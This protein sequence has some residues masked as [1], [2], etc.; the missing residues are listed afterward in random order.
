MHLK[1]AH[2]FSKMVWQRPAS[3]SYPKV[4]HTFEK[5]INGKVQ[6]FWVQDVPENY[7]AKAV[8]I[9]CCDMVKDEPMCRSLKIFYNKEALEEIRALWTELFQRKLSVICLTK[10]ENGDEKI[11]GLN[12]LIVSSK[13]DPDEYSKIQ[14]DGIKTIF[15][16]LKYMY[17]K[18]NIFDELKIN[19]YLNACGLV[20]LPEFRGHSI[21]LEVLKA[22]EPLSKAMGIPASMTL[23]TAIASQKLA[24]RVGFKEWYVVS[25]DDLAKL[26]PPYI[27]PNI[28]NHTKDC[29]TMVKVFE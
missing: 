7:L 23:F 26:D 18:R 17:D 4:W 5:N 24:A 3:V 20:T 13:D 25:Y 22:R 8:D 21:G 6:K 11:A 9:M 28:S 12:C 15:G 2:N 10:D 19:H 27:F 29:K 16:A 1:I 14:T